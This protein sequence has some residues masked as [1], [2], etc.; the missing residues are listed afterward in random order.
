MD[1]AEIAAAKIATRLFFSA[2]SFA[3]RTSAIPSAWWRSAC[4]SVS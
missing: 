3:F 2:M 4:S 1:A